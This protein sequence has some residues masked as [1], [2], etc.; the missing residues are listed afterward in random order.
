M[1]ANNYGTYTSTELPDF[2]KLTDG[3]IGKINN[4]GASRQAE[5]DLLD[6]MMTEANALMDKQEIFSNQN[7]N[8]FVLSGAETGRSKIAQWNKDLKAGILD[9]KEYKNRIN[10]LQNGWS[11]LAESAKTFD[12]TTQMFLDRQIPGKEGKPPAGTGYEQYLASIHA[13]LADMKNKRVFF[14]PL[15][16]KPYT[17]KITDQ[18]I[19]PSTMTPSVRYFSPNNFL[20]NSIDVDGIIAAGTKNFGDYKIESGNATTSDPTA[21]EAIQKAM[22]TLRNGV[23][24][25][26]RYVAQVLDRYSGDDYDYYRTDEERQAK[27]SDLASVDIEARKAAGKPN[28]TEEELK[29]LYSKLDKQLIRVEANS[30]QVYEPV[31]TEEQR[32]R[33]QEIVMDKI[34]SN[35]DYERTLDEPQYRGGGNKDKKDKDTPTTPGKA[36]DAFKAGD[37]DELSRLTGYKYKFK[38]VNGGK[39]IGLIEDEKKD[40]TK[41]FTHVDD[42]FTMFGYTSPSQVEVWK[43]TIIDKRSKTPSIQSATNANWLKA[44]WKQSE[45]NE[46]VKLGKIKV[47]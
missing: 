7:V 38:V 45:I 2:A 29:S 17:A 26:D 28:Y 25:N 27:I 30:A 18:G 39:G 9:P 16:G 3:L 5:K 35:L 41:I 13:E 24:S 1:A 4:I 6:N 12:K 42:M 32:I 10:N 37:A 19:D 36:F 47:I 33:A 23:L 8:E 44:G 22:I 20:D 34:K 46:A 14:D 40:P 43:K 21:S 15:T 31:I 11:M